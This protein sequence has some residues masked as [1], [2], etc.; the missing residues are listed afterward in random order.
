MAERGGR[1]S[2]RPGV[3]YS[4]RTDLLTQRAPQQGQQT[5]A[6]GAQAQPAAQFITPDM[7][8]KLNDPTARPSEPVTAGLMTGPGPGPEALGYVPPAQIVQKVQAA[9]LRNPT[10]ELRKAIEYLSSKGAL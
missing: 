6:A 10:P 3:G 1:R 4:N 9:Y 8:P 2:G 5:A 7:V